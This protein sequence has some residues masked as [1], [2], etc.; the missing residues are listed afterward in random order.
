M[1][2][3]WINNLPFK[4]L[5]KVMDYS[6]SYFSRLPNEILF[7]ILKHLSEDDKIVIEICVSLF[8]PPTK[9]SVKM[10]KF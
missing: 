5:I 9:V 7:M 10:N 4:H 1:V 6:T 2:C 8:I 3:N